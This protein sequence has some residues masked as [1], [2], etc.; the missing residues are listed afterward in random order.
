MSRCKLPNSAYEASKWLVNLNKN[1]SVLS[2]RGIRLV[3]KDS[4][5]NREVGKF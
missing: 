5:K 1:V 2:A 3:G 4:R